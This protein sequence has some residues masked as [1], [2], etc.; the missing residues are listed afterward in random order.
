LDELFEVTT[1]IQTAII[2]D[3]PVVLLGTEY[4]S[5]LVAFL[6]NSPLVQGAI[7]EGDLARILLTDS[8]SEAVDFV[9][10]TA[11]KSFGLRYRARRKPRRLLFERGV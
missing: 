2:K 6:R 11:I 8:P 5:P 1:L 9:Q 4:W 10:R 7:D 3:F